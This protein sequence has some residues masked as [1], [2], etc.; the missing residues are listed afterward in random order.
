MA[1]Q[2]SDVTLKFEAEGI[3][4]LLADIRKVEA[5]LHRIYSL[6]SGTGPGQ[7]PAIAPAEA[8][9][10]TIPAGQYIPMTSGAP[11]GDPAAGH[12]SRTASARA[13]SPYVPLQAQWTVVTGT[14]GGN[15]VP[16]PP[17]TNLAGAPG[18][19]APAPAG[20]PE[21][22]YQSPGRPP[23]P[24]AA[25]SQYPQYPAQYPAYAPATYPY[26]AVPQPPQMPPQVVPGAAGDLATLMMQGAISP[27]T[28][29]GQR[30]VAPQP[31]Q[32]G[33]RRLDWRQAL[34]IAA[35]P[36]WPWNPW[37]PAAA[38]EAFYMGHQ[39]AQPF[40]QMA[41]PYWD[42]QA[43]MASGRYVTP[44]D[45]EMQKVQR[46]GAYGQAGGAIA[47]L[48]IGGLALGLAPFTAGASTVSGAVAL[49]GLSA[50]LGG[51]YG[52]GRAQVRTAELQRERDFRIELQRLHALMGRGSVPWD[53]LGA[54]I[55]AEAEALGV[56]GKPSIPYL[57]I[58]TALAG[59]FPELV[60][61]NVGTRRAAEW[62]YGQGLRP[63]AASFVRR[64]GP[65]GE[66]AA[67]AV[68]QAYM[69][70][71]G[72]PMMRE[73]F[74][75]G[76]IRP[77]TM[78]AASLV[79]FLTGDFDM[80]NW[81]VAAGGVGAE[82][83]HEFR[84]L[85]ML[86]AG[87]R[88]ELAIAQAGV[89]IARARAQWLQATGAS[90]EQVAG[91]MREAL[92]DL[93]V[94]VAALREQRDRVVRMQRE[95]P[96]AR[97]MLEQERRRLDAAVRQA[98]TERFM[99]TVR[100]PRMLE[101]EERVGLRESDI[102]LAR[103]FMREQELRG[104]TFPER[105]PA[106]GRLAGHYG[107]LAE[108]YEGILREPWLTPQERAQYRVLYRQARQQQQWEIPHERTMGQI[109]WTEALYG[110]RIGTR[111]AELGVYQT[112]RG[113]PAGV[114]ERELGIID[115]I[116]SKRKKLQEIERTDVMTAE[117]RLRLQQQ[118]NELTARETTMRYEAARGWVQRTAGLYETVAAGYETRAGRL[119][120][121]GAGGAETYGVRR[122]AIGRYEQLAGI[123]EQAAASTSNIEDKARW[124]QM[125]EG[126]R[127]QAEQARLADIGR[128]PARQRQAELAAEYETMRLSLSSE[129][130]DIRAAYYQQFEA[131]RG[132]EEQIR[133]Q[134]EERGGAANLTDEERYRFNQALMEARGM[135][136][137][138]RKAL[139]E[140]WQD[141]LISVMSGM[142]ESFNMVMP[143]LSYMSAVQRGVRHRFFGATRGQREAYRMRPLTWFAGFGRNTPMG[144]LQ[145]ALSGAPTPIGPESPFLPVG[146]GDLTLTGTPELD[147][148]G[149]E[150]PKQAPADVLSG[151]AP[152]LPQLSL[153]TGERHEKEQQK[154]ALELRLVFEDAAGNYF[155][156]YTKTLHGV[157]QQK[158]VVRLVRPSPSHQQL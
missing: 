87:S 16:M 96:R 65:A 58:A 86:Q 61:V 113:E 69:S 62:G 53:V 145:E 24:P 59:P 99:M 118:I 10:G 20:A 71:W 67:Q 144:M 127:A 150:L 9:R 1:G 105:A 155:G 80:G 111:Q 38:A 26:Q 101:F 98:E 146:E 34:G 21:P 70:P 93:D 119:A 130:G 57:H 56:G 149:K 19:A 30:P 45:I 108:T 31:T 46:W 29:P 139:E 89:P 44:E 88:F 81:L 37:A 152:G 157:S 47:G 107:R 27:P 43:M 18:P 51:L 79:P 76:M 39:I 142:P 95:H 2:S 68:R 66:E 153:P 63:W 120:L 151:L 60:G 97:R 54:Q 13:Q 100:E 141:R 158:E 131:A 85:G 134:I 14:P 72:F 40:L 115:E 12:P 49:A 52:T 136:I 42:I 104:L 140:G 110:A 126:L 143:A 106:Y 92:P 74:E 4:E 41:Q 121:T 48:V 11:P 135:Q 55:Q 22:A 33:Q 114:Y 32:P 109:G 8:G 125:A 73:L 82:M 23:G 7:V 25:P 50:G 124:T 36:F 138:A 129:R 116:I 6:G 132:R 94:Q 15:P 154:V 133:R 90:A 78:G 148:L 117:E 103:L 91:A 35:I 112:I 64:F 147:M 137:Q 156:D 77:G 123:F 122:G 83:A 3:D 75:T 5:E 84:R 17:G 128:M 102:D 28:A